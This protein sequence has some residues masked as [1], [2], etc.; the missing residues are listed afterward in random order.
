ML[1]LLIQM[2]KRDYLLVSYFKKSSVNQISVL[3]DE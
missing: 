1:E 2:D 3:D